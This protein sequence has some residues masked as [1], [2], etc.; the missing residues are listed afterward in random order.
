MISFLS[1]H[2]MKLTGEECQASHL[3]V[4]RALGNKVCPNRSFKHVGKA[5]LSHL[6]PL[7]FAQSNHRILRKDKTL[8]FTPLS[9]GVFVMQQKLRQTS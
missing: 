5:M 8:L 9:L 2:F 4:E 1:A 6:A 3:G 7:S